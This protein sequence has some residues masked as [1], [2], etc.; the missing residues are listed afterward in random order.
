MM[1]SSYRVQ[2]RFEL[3]LIAVGQVTSILCVDP[4]DVLV[5]PVRQTTCF[6]KEVAA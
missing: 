3:L 2:N 4:H 6:D 5:L 1:G